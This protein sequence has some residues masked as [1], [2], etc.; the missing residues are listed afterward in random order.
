MSTLRDAEHVPCR[1]C[2]ASTLQCQVTHK[3][4]PARSLAACPMSL[5]HPNG[6]W[7]EGADLSPGG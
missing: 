7:E 1:G 6:P 3:R 5:C 4:P 2:D